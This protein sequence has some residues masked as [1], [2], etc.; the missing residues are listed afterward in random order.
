[1]TKAAFDLAHVTSVAKQAA[2]VI[3]QMNESPDIDLTPVHA[4]SQLFRPLLQNEGVQFRSLHTSTIIR[5]RA[6][7]KSVDKQLNSDEKLRSFLGEV[8]GTTRNI[9]KM[10]GEKAKQLQRTQEFLLNLAS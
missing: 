9:E 5:L 3:A 7:A 1:M 2:D 6:A 8:V 10:R 4:C